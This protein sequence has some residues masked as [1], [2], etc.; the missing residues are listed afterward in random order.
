MIG[1]HRSLLYCPGW[2]YCIESPTEL[3]NFLKTSQFCNN[4]DMLL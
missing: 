1:Q 4:C 2:L 3:Q